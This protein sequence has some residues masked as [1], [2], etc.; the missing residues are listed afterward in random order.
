[1]NVSGNFVPI[2]ATFT[3]IPINVNA[4]EFFYWQ[5]NFLLAILLNFI[6]KLTQTK[7]CIFDLN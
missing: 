3:A 5:L 6:S 1:M 2:K 4:Y 7:I